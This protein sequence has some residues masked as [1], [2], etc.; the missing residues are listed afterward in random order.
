MNQAALETALELDELIQD[1]PILEGRS[2]DLPCL[3]PR[4]GEANR[5]GRR[6]G[7]RFQRLHSIDEV[8]S[9]NLVS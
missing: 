9:S 3:G 8:V 1:D 4:D 7:S 2:M 5:A 6:P